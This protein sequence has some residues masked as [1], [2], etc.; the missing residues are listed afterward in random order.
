MATNDAGDHGRIPY[1]RAG[2]GALLAEWQRDMLVGVYTRYGALEEFIK[3]AEEKSGGRL[4]EW[5]RAELAGMYNRYGALEVHGYVDK[6]DREYDKVDD[7]LSDL[8]DEFLATWPGHG[9]VV[10]GEQ[11]ALDLG[12][13][14][15]EVRTLLDEAEDIQDTRHD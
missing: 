10:K 11:V 12:D 1:T 4:T 8:V 15:D 5:Q 7:E 3:D 13:L 14:T 9:R 2:G 6:N